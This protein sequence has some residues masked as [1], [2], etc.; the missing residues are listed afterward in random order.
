MKTWKNSP[1]GKPSKGG[2]RGRKTG[3]ETPSG[4]P[5]KSPWKGG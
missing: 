1:R 2:W 5:S 3:H 4:A